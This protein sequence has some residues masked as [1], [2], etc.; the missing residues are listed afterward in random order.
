MIEDFIQCN[1]LLLPTAEC[2]DIICSM[3]ETCQNF[4]GII[5]LS[6]KVKLKKNM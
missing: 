6:V 1:S 2:L 4:N 3:M 5:H